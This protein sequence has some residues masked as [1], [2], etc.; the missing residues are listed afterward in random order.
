MDVGGVVRGGDREA[1]FMI[2]F[3]KIAGVLA[4]IS[5]EGVHIRGEVEAPGVGGV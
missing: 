3:A 2:I 4:H 5:V 1:F